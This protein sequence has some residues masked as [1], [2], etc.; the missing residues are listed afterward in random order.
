MS[1]KLARK[2][3]HLTQSELAKRS[4][5][6]QPV[7]ARYESGDRPLRLAPYAN[8]T[9]IAAALGIST[10]ELIAL[11]DKIPDKR[12][13]TA[14]RRLGQQLR[15]RRRKEHGSVLPTE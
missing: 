8:L 12:D 10:D 11:A 4:G 13:P 7:I 14:G 1:L 6:D 3:A 15:A 9:R 5:L 2:I